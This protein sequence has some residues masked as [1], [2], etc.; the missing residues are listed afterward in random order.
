M[1]IFVPSNNSLVIS[2]PNLLPLGA[3][4][5]DISHYFFLLKI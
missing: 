1:P 3:F 2:M 4:R 5:A